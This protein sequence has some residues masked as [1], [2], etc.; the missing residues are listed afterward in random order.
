MWATVRRPG[1]VL[2]AGQQVSPRSELAFSSSVPAV[3]RSGRGIV[4]WIGG[5]FATLMAADL[6]PD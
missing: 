1:Q 5:D 4:T 2:E 6:E 3:D